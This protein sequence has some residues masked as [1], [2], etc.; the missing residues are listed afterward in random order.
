VATGDADQVISS[1][2]WASLEQIEQANRDFDSR[3]AAS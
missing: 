3:A 1:Q 2:L